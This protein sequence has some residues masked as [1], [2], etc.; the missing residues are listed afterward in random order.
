M[1]DRVA[2]VIYEINPWVSVIFKQLP[3]ALRDEYRAKARA[4]IAAMRDPTEKMWNAPV[5]ADVFVGG[6]YPSGEESEAI[7]QAMIDEALK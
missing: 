7:W 2:G 1:V 5:M 4:A 3:S 6:V